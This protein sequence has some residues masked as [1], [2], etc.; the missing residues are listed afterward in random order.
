M[1]NMKAI[2]RL[3]IM[4][5]LNKLT[6][7]AVIRSHSWRLDILSQISHMLNLGVSWLTKGPAVEVSL[8]PL[9][10]KIIVVMMIPRVARVIPIKVRNTLRGIQL[11][12]VKYNLKSLSASARK[13]AIMS[14]MSR[15]S[16]K[17]PL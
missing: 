4:K 5:L 7:K 13:I 17:M 3:S 14:F 6:K 8:L 2:Q 11:P 9:E 10:I 16:S 12:A 15:E 1:P